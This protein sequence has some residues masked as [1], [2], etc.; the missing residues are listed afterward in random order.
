MDVVAIARDLV[1]ERHPDARAA[2]L[3]GS[4][5]TERRTAMS[6]LDVVVLLWGEP[7]PY[8]ESF[9][10]GGLPVEMF[11]HTE[12][13]WGAFVGREVG[14][15]RS[16]LLFMCADG[17][18]LFDVDGVG[19]RI[20]ARAGELADAGPPGVAGDVIGDLRYAITDLLDDLAG[21][22]DQDERLFIG[23]ELVRRTGEL[24]LIS[25]RSWRG[26]GKWLARRLEGAE[27][28]LAGRLR[29][30]LLEVLGGR[31]ELLVGVVDEVLGAVGGRL[32]EGYRRGGTP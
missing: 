30:G 7:A 2:F 8:R 6:D 13:T 25:E 22:R 21:S 12:G 19:A 26:G 3:G 15:G 23:T 16:P 9:R 24:A 14:A 10:S 28:G 27:P 1:L 20:A 4:V 5:L 32:W 29:W 18:L 31:D 11:V 17:E